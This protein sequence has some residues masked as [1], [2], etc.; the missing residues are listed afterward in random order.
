MNDVD[1]FIFEKTATAFAAISLYV[2]QLLSQSFIGTVSDG[3]RPFLFSTLYF[4]NVTDVFWN[5]CTEYIFSLLLEVPTPLFHGK[6][7]CSIIIITYREN[8]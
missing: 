3:R 2:K 1:V 4:F 6:C 8:T 7:E 5:G